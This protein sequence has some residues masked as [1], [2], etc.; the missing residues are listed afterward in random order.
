MIDVVDKKTRSRMM[1]GIRGWDTRPEL[2]VRRYL[3]AAGQR[4]T[5]HSS[6]LPGKPDIALPKY[7]TAIFVHGCFWHRHPSCR[8]AAEAKSNRDFWTRKFADNIERDAKNSD[9]LT[10]ASWTFLVIWECR[11]NSERALDESL[12][13]NL[14]NG[15]AD[16]G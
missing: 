12:W 1:A 15:E 16:C 5:L 7:R 3:H 11:T 14:A 13:R 8:F 4:F 10:T 6:R 2:K 9:A